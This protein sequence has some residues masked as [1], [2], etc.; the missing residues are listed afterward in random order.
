MNYRISQLRSYLFNVIDDLTNKNDYKI[1]AD[2]LGE[3]GDYSLDKIPTDSIIEKWVTGVEIHRD[4]F[5]LRSR[6]SYS[7]DEINNLENIGFFEDFE[8][9]IK[10]NNREGVLPDINGIQSI[11]CLNCGTMVASNDGNSATFDIQIQI[12]YKINEGGS[13]SL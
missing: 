9:K 2:F 1:N 13:V 8:N 6:K 12:T 10:S 7:Q 3:E 11:E 5:S 4:V